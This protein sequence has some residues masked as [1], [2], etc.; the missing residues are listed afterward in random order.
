[1]PMHSKIKQVLMLVIPLFI[2]TSISWQIQI[3]V[4]PHWVEGSALVCCFWQVS[5]HL[6]LCARHFADKP[7]C[8]VLHDFPNGLLVF[9]TGTGKTFTGVLLVD[10]LLR[11]SSQTI[12]VVCYTNH[13]LDQVRREETSTTKFN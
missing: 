7:H 13:A 4:A 8:L 5:C 11:R 12:L 1:M 10:S 2:G 3:Y 9:L 6:T